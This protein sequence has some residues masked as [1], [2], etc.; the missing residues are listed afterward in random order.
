VVRELQAAG[1]TLV[2]F[3]CEIPKARTLFVERGGRSV[4]DF[5]RQVTAIAAAGFPGG[6]GATV[7][8]AITADGAVRPLPDLSQEVLGDAA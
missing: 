5:E 2:W 8:Q 7:V 1:V 4:A 6:L 3:E